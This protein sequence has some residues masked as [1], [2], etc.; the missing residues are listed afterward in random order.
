[1]ESIAFNRLLRIVLIGFLLVSRPIMAHD[2][3]VCQ[4]QAQQELA[5]RGC[6][7]VLDQRA[8]QAISDIAANATLAENL[9]AENGLWVKISVNNA[10]ETAVNRLMALGIPDAFFLYLFKV[11]DNR[12]ETLLNL[13]EQMAFAQRPVLNRFLY[14]EVELAAKST[15]T[16]YIYYRTH[17]KTPLQPKLLTTK[18]LVQLDTQNDLLNGSIFGTLIILA[19]VVFF[20]PQGAGHADSR[21]YAIL[22]IFCLLFLSQIQGYNFQFLWPEQ[23]VW[24]MQAPGVIA[25]G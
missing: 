11:R 15:T 20:N 16:F 1:V 4:L 8:G 2:V 21:N 25:V 9:K 17:G 24:N 12:L 6:T 23:A 13:D 5:L 22:I 19:M 14:G 7:Q 10:N 3:E 18:K